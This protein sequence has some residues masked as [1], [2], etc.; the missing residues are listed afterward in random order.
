[1]KIL[2]LIHVD[3][4]QPASIRDWALSKGYSMDICRLFAGDSLPKVE[5]YDW[6]V[7]MGGPQSTRKLEEF[8]YLKDEVELILKAIELDK[9]VLGFC[10]G[11]QLIGTAL[12]GM[13]EESPYKEIGVY[14]VQLTDEGKKDPLLQGVPDEFIAAHWHGEMAGIPKGSVVLGKSIGCPRQIIRF[15]KGVYGFQCHMELRRDEVRGVIENCRAEMS[16][17][18]FVQSESEFL[19]SDFH[20]ANA[21]MDRVLENVL[22]LQE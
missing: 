15:G 12:G 6:L 1:M 16:E 21:V 5:E 11:A 18:E 13:T 3:F 7:V 14:P 2:C 17:G 22:L 10:L 4:E 19:A 8:P 20:P 9:V